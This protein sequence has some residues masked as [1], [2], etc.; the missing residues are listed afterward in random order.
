MTPI[1]S[2]AIG[3]TRRRALQNL[4]C[5]PSAVAINT[6]TFGHILEGYGA[7]WSPEQVIDACAARGFAGIAFWTRELNGRAVEIGE[8]T[9]SAGLRVTGLCRPP[10]LVGPN[11]PADRAESLKGLL[12]T[13]DVAA[14]LKAES[15]T[16]VVGGVIPESRSIVGSLNAVADIV[17]RA[18]DHAA[19]GN[20][21][22][23]LEPLHPVYAGDRSCLVTVR[24]AVDMCNRIGHSHVGL[25]VD[26][27][28]VWWDLTLAEQL[29][30]LPSDKIFGFH[31]CDW[32]AETRDILLDRGMMG[33]GIADIRGLRKI[34]ENAGYSGPS[35]VEVFSAGNWWL[36]D[37]DEVLDTIIER[38]RTVF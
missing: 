3:G 27:Y 17:A 29:Q 14:E 38:V 4:S 30:R 1:A 11:A 34:V 36:R 35:E 10:Y 26:V 19:S 28:H 7:G 18:A 6:A 37:P 23:A 13:I 16:V 24:D 33:D 31:I 5:A 32:L 8:R 2:G 15:L 12:E 21:R 20:V 9:R 22:L 25:A